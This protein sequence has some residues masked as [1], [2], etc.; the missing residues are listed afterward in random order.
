MWEQKS[1]KFQK[2]NLKLRAIFLVKSQITFFYLIFFGGPFTW[3]I[4][5]LLQSF[6]IR[7]ISKMN[8]KLRVI[9]QIAICIFY[10]TLN[11]DD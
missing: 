1:A 5:L 10:L 8:L 6:W 11:T 9:F 2:M 3:L 4:L 7:Q